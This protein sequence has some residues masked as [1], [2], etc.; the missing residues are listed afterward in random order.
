MYRALVFLL[1]LIVSPSATADTVTIGDDLYVA[2]PDAATAPPAQRDLFAAGLSVTVSQPTSGDAHAAGV[3]VAFESQTGG[4]LYAAGP[5]VTLRAPVGGDASA[6]GL[7]VRSTAEARI[8]GN[9]RMAGGSVTV[10]G[11]VDGAL[12]AAAGEL[13]LNAPVAGDALLAAQT[14]RFG[15]EASVAGTLQYTAPEPL[16]IP[17]SVAPASRIR[18]SPPAEGAQWREMAEDWH[19][20]MPIMWQGPSFLT[21]LIGALL[22]LAFLLIVGALFLSFMPARVD[23]LHAAARSR[24]GL[25]LLAGILGLSALVGLV[26]VTAMTLVGLPLVPVVVLAIMVLWVLGYLLGVFTVAMKVFE[27]FNRPDA[28]ERRGQ[29]LAV[30]AAGLVGAA[31]LNFVPFLG[32]ILNVG[33]LLLGLGA[34]TMALAARVP[35]E[36]RAREVPPSAPD[37]SPPAAEG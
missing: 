36:P 7:S 29:Q 17:E 8:G 16:E 6:M 27:L 18:Y 31:L 24:P 21:W 22:T 2:G 33:L 32:W 35:R 25:S 23:R 14:L 10:E 12:T 4:D 1:A 11:P 37:R 20:E 28:P 34:L 3:S 9:T 5:S 19:R 13:L 30:L 15:P 26:P